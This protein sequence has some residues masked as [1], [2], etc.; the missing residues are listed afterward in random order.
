MVVV[1]AKPGPDNEYPADVTP[2]MVA[3]SPDA[4]GATGAT[5]VTGVTGVTGQDTGSDDP[6]SARE[7][8][9]TPESGLAGTLLPREPE[10]AVPEPARTVRTTLFQCLVP[11]IHPDN[12]AY[13]VSLEELAA[14]F[15]GRYSRWKSLPGGPEKLRIQVLALA[16]DAPG[17]AWWNQTVMRNA[18][19][20][21]G[22][23]FLSRGR[24][25]LESVAGNH[26]AVGYVHLPL[27]LDTPGAAAPLSVDGVKV[28]VG[29][30]LS[31]EYPLCRAM[32]VV[33]PDFDPTSR[34]ASFLSFVSQRRDILMGMAGLKAMDPPVYRPR[35]PEED[36]DE[37]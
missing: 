22:A 27:L 36:G 11:I 31:G 26:R 9:S 3:A 16:E 6:G 5:G 13:N 24:A 30:V 8:A 28:D 37:Q 25:V 17:A 4:P 20:F 34:A 23:L 18:R 14:V 1:A 29:T 2:D 12:P 15:A 32:Q 33:V 10:A 21:M 7:D 19:V 35:P